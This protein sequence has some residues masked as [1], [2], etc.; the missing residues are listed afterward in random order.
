MR[1][2]I[3]ATSIIL[4]T[5]ALGKNIIFNDSTAVMASN[6]QKD[7]IENVKQVSNKIVWR[8]L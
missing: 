5:F 6:Y 3:L 4:S 2:T 7:K 1:K 8:I